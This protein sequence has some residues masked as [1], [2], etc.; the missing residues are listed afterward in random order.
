MKAQRIRHGCLA[1]FRHQYCSLGMGWWDWDP[2][3]AVVEEQR[4]HGL[5]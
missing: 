5:A 1:V 2:V 4:L 3:L